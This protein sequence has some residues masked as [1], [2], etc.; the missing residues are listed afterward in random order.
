[1]MATFHIASMVQSGIESGAWNGKILVFG[2]HGA[3]GHAAAF[4]ERV[5]DKRAGKAFSS[6]VREEAGRSDARG[7]GAARGCFSIEQPERGGEANGWE[8][9]RD[10]LQGVWQ[11]CAGGSGRGV[12]HCA[13]SASSINAISFNCARRLRG[14]ASSAIRRLV[15]LILIACD[16]GMGLYSYGPLLGTYF[17]SGGAMQ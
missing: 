8:D 2:L 7:N 17:S 4:M 14:R 3:C 12:G 1:M 13:R 16:G 15:L 9:T 11:M 5:F 6:L 10:A